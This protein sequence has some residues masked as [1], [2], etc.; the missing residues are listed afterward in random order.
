LASIRGH[1]PIS[2]PAADSFEHL[3]RSLKPNIVFINPS[4]YDERFMEEIGFFD[5][6]KGLFDEAVRVS[7]DEFRA[8]LVRDND[9]PIEVTLDASPYSFNYHRHPELRRF[10]YQHLSFCPVFMLYE[11]AIAFAFLT[12][13]RR[14]QLIFGS[15]IGVQ[16]S[17]RSDGTAQKFIESLK[18]K[19]VA[20]YPDCRGMVF[21]V[22]S[23][24]VKKVEAII[25]CLEKEKEFRSAEDKI[26][27]KNF[28][29]VLWF[30]GLGAHFFV[31]KRGRPLDYLQPCLD[32]ELPKEEWRRHE[33][34]QWL[35][36][37]QSGRMATD[38][39]KTL[40]AQ[41]VDYVIVEMITKAQAITHPNIGFDYLVYAHDL[42][43]RVLKN[44]R[45][46]GVALGRV[47]RKKDRALLRRWRALNLKI[48]M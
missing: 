28:L 42:K 8:N 40:F 29:R 6:Y 24:D 7:E 12:Y 47:V 10:T 16:E 13:T 30:E 4:E 22:E 41:V 45:S 18:E 19:L 37:L 25:A 26:E 27:I 48:S 44:A 2:N 35:G 17:W 15:Y 39:V 23:F 5:L 31:D 9:E 11:K 36:W 38:N 34:V 20:D 1:D 43:K 21:E 32:P 46:K 3:L 33:K 14:K